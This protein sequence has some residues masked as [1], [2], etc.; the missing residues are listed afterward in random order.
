[1]P[2][3]ACFENSEVV[4]GAPGLR[5]LTVT[6]LQWREATRRSGCGRFKTA[7]AL[8]RLVRG[9]STRFVRPFWRKA[10]GLC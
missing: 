3:P 8:G 1:M 9:P 6:P 7:G 10:Q 2:L 5:Y 4:A